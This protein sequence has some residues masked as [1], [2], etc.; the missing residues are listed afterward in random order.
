[1]T[2]EEIKVGDVL[3][4]EEKKQHYMVCWKNDKNKEIGG[5]ISSNKS[6]RVNIGNHV[7]IGIMSIRNLTFK[8][9]DS[10]FY[11][12][13]KKYLDNCKKVFEVSPSV[14][15][16]FNLF[17]D[18]VDSDFDVSIVIKD[19]DVDVETNVLALMDLNKKV[20]DLK[21]Q[22]TEESKKFIIKHYSEVKMSSERRICEVG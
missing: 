22:L 10:L 17:E 4:N 21:N 3:Y 15:Y 7:E 20:S 19:D 8:D 9:S 6:A 14:L 13:N 5:R 12:D 16:Q 2:F 1:M 18:F 11:E